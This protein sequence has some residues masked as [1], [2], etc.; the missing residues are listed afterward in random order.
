MASW[1]SH[2]EEIWNPHSSEFLDNASHW[3][4]LRTLRILYSPWQAGARPVET[5]RVVDPFL[6]LLSVLFR[7]LS[8]NTAQEQDQHPRLE[9]FELILPLPPDARPN[10][11]ILEE[12]AESLGASRWP[13]LQ[14]IR[15][16]LKL[17]RKPIGADEAVVGMAHLQNYADAIR[18]A[19]R[20]PT[21]LDNGRTL[22]ILPAQAKGGTFD[23]AGG[24]RLST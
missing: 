10:L 17:L 19:F 4:F 3:T 15:I 5:S 8:H 14:H 1:V 16:F 23:L 22:D 6:E 2:N 18:R 24:P 12:L 9:S 11:G 13:S 21:A 7:Q 20:L